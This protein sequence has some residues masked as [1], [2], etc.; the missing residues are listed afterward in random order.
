MLLNGWETLQTLFR[1]FLGLEQ[2]PP[3]IEHQ[4]EPSSDS[5]QL[6]SR[7][8]LRAK[9]KQFEVQDLLNGLSRDKSILKNIKKMPDREKI[10]LVN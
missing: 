7:I 1:R 9:P 6:K 8:I 10:K 2:N 4:I 5:R 3:A